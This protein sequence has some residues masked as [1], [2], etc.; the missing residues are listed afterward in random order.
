MT[1]T[2]RVQQAPTDNDTVTGPGCSDKSCDTLTTETHGA[3]LGARV[4]G[5]VSVPA[6]Q[7]AH[8]LHIDSEP[9]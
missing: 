2:A 9:P 7:W 4:Q 6:T 3:G 1:Q 5:G 8:S